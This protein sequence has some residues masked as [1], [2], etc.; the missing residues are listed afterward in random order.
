MAKFYIYCRASTPEV[1]HPSH[2]LDGQK[3]ML[4]SYVRK[5]GL[6]IPQV[7]LESA[8]AM[9]Q[10]PLFMQMLQGIERG[11]ADG[12]L[13]IDISRLA[14][15]LVDGQ[16]LMDLLDRG[17]MKEIRT[18]TFLLNKSSLLLHLSMLQHERESL[19]RSIRRGLQVRKWRR[20][21]R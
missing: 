17:T 8:S 11:E 13:T 16:C 4:T 19:S 6:I 7:F 15:N 20:N 2:S 1:T 21:L 10:R 14:R 12:I 5:H 18:P 3:K 9:R